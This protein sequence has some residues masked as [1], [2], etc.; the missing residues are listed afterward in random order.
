MES[1][2]LYNMD[3]TG[4]CYV[5]WS[6]SGTERQALTHMLGVEWWLSEAGEAWGWGKG[7]QWVLN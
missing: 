3:R 5:K 4:G 2:H 1:F 6:K 7:G